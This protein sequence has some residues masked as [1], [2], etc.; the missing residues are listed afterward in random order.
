VTIDAAQHDYDNRQNGDQRVR[1]V[2]TYAPLSFDAENKSIL[3]MGA[4]NTLYYP[5]A[6]AS[7]GAQR[8]YFLIG[9]DATEPAAAPAARLTAF[10]I[11]FGDSEA[12]GILVVNGVNEVTGVNDNSWYTLDGRRL[13]GKPSHAG[14]YINKGIKVVIK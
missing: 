5:L 14:V 6:G 3:M 1:F 9:D 12:T 13:V 8:A 11:N 2:G 7:I 4:A 10:N